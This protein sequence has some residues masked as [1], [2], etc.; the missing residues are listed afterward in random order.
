MPYGL[1]ISAAGANA[2]SKRMDVIANN[3]ANVDTAGFKKDFA[4]LQERYAEAIERGQVPEGLGRPEDVGGG[5]RF[6]ETVTDFATGT[7][8]P[9]GIETD[10]AI[11]GDGFFVVQ[12]DGKPLLTKAGNFRVN[13]E[14]FLQTQ[15]GLSVMATDDTPIRIDP[16][17]PRTFERDGTIRQ[18]ADIFELKVVEPKSLGDLVKSGETYF[19]PLAPT[20]IV[21]PGDRKVL[22]GY[23]EQSTVNPATEM[24]AMIEASRAYEAN[25]RMIQNQDQAIGTL[26][27]RLLS[28][29]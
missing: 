11:D 22:S 21:P 14:G 12:K 23:Q 5:V 20:P 13:G 28:Q 1:Y 3:L 26:I 8:K 10:L 29:Q 16:S 27:S 7:L 25:V 18:G 19:T 17:L 4:V 9:T 24:M 15:D 6:S 2:Q